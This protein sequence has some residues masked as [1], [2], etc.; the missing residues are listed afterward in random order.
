MITGPDGLPIESHPHDFVHMVRE[1]MAERLPDADPRAFAVVGALAAS[2]FFGVR[3]KTGAA[4]KRAWMLRPHGPDISEIWDPLVPG[5]VWG[6]VDGMPDPAAYVPDAEG[7]AGVGLLF[8]ANA[9]TYTAVA[10]RIHA[11]LTGTEPDDD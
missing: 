10:R 4:G 9:G 11:L 1:V 7:T 5:F 6:Y 8:D 3:Y 2:R